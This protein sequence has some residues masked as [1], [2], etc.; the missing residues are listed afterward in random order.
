MA[1]YNEQIKEKAIELI[2]D[3]FFSISQVCKALNISRQAFY[4][5]MKEKP[6]FAESVNEAML[7]RDEAIL[8]MAYSSISK[9]LKDGKT[10]IEKDIYVPDEYNPGNLKLKSRVVTRKDYHPDPAT[11]KMILERNDKK[12]KSE[13]LKIKNGEKEKEVNWSEA[14]IGGAKNEKLKVK[15]EIEKIEE[16]EESDIVEEEKV[17]STQKEEVIVPKKVEK[18]EVEVKT[19]ISHLNKNRSRAKTKS[20]KMTVKDVRKRVKFVK[21]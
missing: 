1:K 12:V 19:G 3:E 17:E 8:A 18:P 21:F 15:S 10:V 4:G 13:K 2:E 14:E 7:R 9:R 16:I 11:I 20:K 6:D 5:W